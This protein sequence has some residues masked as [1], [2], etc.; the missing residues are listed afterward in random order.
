MIQL[1]AALVTLIGGTLAV[2]NFS[3]F[4][5][6]PAATPPDP[7]PTPTSS[8]TPAFGGEFPGTRDTILNEPPT[9]PPVSILTHVRVSSRNGYDRVVFEFRDNFPGY[10]VGYVT[11]PT[12][13][14]SG[15]DVEIAGDAY[16]QVRLEGAQAHDEGESTLADRS[17]SVDLDSIREVV[18]TGDAGGQVT[19][20]IGLVRPL[21]F[22]VER[23]VDPFRVMV[24]IAHP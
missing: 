5:D 2:L 12:E 16:L 13:E 6:D 20:V 15:R 3:P 11:N 7:S 18:V 19:A 4:D 8:A 9:V 1:A 23:G 17:Y 21:D 24:D 22:R 14:F 10:R